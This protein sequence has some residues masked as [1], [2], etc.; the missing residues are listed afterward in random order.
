MNRAPFFKERLSPLAAYVLVG[1][2]AL[3]M[4]APF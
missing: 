2:G 3:V 4:L 1:L